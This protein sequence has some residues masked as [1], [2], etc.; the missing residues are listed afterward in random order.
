VLTMAR[1]I[2]PRRATETPQS[3]GTPPAR[4]YLTSYRFR[5]GGGEYHH[6]AR[7]LRIVAGKLF[8][9][10]AGSAHGKKGQGMVMNDIH[11]IARKKPIRLGM[12]L[13]LPQK[14]VLRPI[15]CRLN[16]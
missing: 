12:I 13:A 4:A 5:G 2:V 16:A 15:Y 8:G 3:G 14:S 1:C 9:R 10:C 6:L 7:P 11:D